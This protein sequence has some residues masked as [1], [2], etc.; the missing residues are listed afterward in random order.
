MSLALEEAE[1]GKQYDSCE[2]TVTADD[3]DNNW[4]Q[5][6]RER[7]IVILAN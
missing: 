2:F 4:R 1:N 5:Y 6:E 7:E 3:D